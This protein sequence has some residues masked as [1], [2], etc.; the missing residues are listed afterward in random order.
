MPRTRAVSHSSALKPNS[1]PLIITGE[2]A[3][4]RSSTAAEFER[5]RCACPRGRVP[6]AALGQVCRHSADSARG[7]GKGMPAKGIHF[8]SG[9]NRGVVLGAAA[10]A[11]P[12]SA[13]RLAHSR[14]RFGATSDLLEGVAFPPPPS[15]SPPS[16]LQAFL[17]AATTGN[18]GSHQHIC[19]AVRIAAA[20]NQRGHAEA[21]VSCA[22]YYTYTTRNITGAT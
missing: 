7:G 10:R 14:H 4:P 12:F 17:P 1:A 2:R 5:R 6:N 18:K 3:G 16:R 8:S 11:M 19:C 20:A 21:T 15:P 22:I 9:C 13:V